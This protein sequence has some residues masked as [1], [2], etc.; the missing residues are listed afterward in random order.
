MQMSNLSYNE[1]KEAFEKTEKVKD[2]YEY[3]T[4]LKPQKHDIIVMTCGP[5][6]DI[7]TAAELHRILD[8]FFQDSE[9]ECALVTLPN[10]FEMQVF[11]QDDGIEY[12]TD[13][14]KRLMTEKQYKNF[15]RTEFDRL[16][17]DDLR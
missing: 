5:D 14:V 9:L 10:E 12:I 7:E 17:G 13:Y 3:I 16:C 2:I 6:T 4:L 15:I 1:L 8:K 11:C